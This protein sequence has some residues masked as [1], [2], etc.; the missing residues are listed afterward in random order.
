MRPLVGLICLL[1]LVFPGVPARA[2]TRSELT[3]LLSTPRAGVTAVSVIDL[4]SGAVVMNHRAHEL[5]KPASV[6]K[7]VTTAAALDALGP[8]YRFETSVFSEGTGAPH[9]YVEGGGD[10]ALAIEELWLLARAVRRRGVTAVGDIVLDSSGFVTTRERT[11]Q[12]AYSA[13]SSALP[14]NFNS[15]GIEIIGGQPGQPAR[16]SPEIWELPVSLRGRIV[17]GAANAWSVD[18]DSG[19]G[20]SYRIAG[21][22]RRG[23]SATVYRSVPDPEA[24]FGG[25]FQAFLQSNGVTVR[26]RVRAGQIPPGATLLVR[27]RSKPLTDVLRD[28]NHYS[29]NF[30]A[31]QVLLALSA[32]GAEPR[33]RERGL[34]RIAGFLRAIG[35]AE[36]EVRLEDAS[37]LSHGNRISAAALNR[38]L[39]EMTRRDDL[40]PEFEISLAVAGRNGTLR[41]RRIGPGGV[42]RAKT[43]TIN[44]VS[45]LAG[46][47]TSGARRRF[48]FTIISN[49]VVKD[50]AVRLED[51]IV[52]VL[53]RAGA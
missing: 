19:G 51:R 9:L 4:D 1:G 44:G 12:R 23:E 10:P 21:T 8:E 7:I 11:G 41:G 52:E 14:F 3:A 20:L 13:G 31:E 5:L 27:H 43:G 15:L 6:L 2:D 18:E 32:A 48:A 33:R 16:V 22:V 30:T 36:G 38:V 53:S 17:T 42:V 46:Y 50:Q 24:Y 28:L 26:G 34:E 40:H 47:V 39:V 45:S 37:G 25:A 49:G 35:V 29:N